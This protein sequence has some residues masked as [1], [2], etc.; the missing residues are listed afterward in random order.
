MKNPKSTRF[1]KEIT[2]MTTLNRSVIC[3]RLIGL[4]N[5]PLS[6]PTSISTS[7]LYDTQNLLNYTFLLVKKIKILNRRRFENT[8]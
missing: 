5:A 1:N 2:N 3:P 8:H 7:K 4:L 6:I